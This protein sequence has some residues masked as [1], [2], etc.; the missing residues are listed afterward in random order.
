[1]QSLASRWL[2]ILVGVLIVTLT[3]LTD[4]RYNSPGDLIIFAAILVLLN[5]VLRPIVLILTLPV[6]ILTL[7]LFTLVVNALMFW[8]AD[9]LYPGVRFGSFLSAMVAAM[10]VS[11]FT[12]AAG[13]LIR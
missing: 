7:G 11:I 2:L 13:I 1:M 5:A 10:I 9:Q 3:G 4:F 8:L 6:N 12:F